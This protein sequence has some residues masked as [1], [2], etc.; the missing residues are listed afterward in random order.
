MARQDFHLFFDSNA[1]RFAGELKDDLEPARTALDEL[2]KYML[3]VDKEITKR[4]A[5]G[6]FTAMVKGLG[7]AN[8]LIGELV[9]QLGDMA[10]EFRDIATQLKPVL[11]AAQSGGLAVRSRPDPTVETGTS[12]VARTSESAVRGAD[13]DRLI[14]AYLDKRSE[15]RTAE[16]KSDGLS[17]NALAQAEAGIH[18]IADDLKR[19]EKNWK[20]LTGAE[21]SLASAAQSFLDNLPT[22]PKTPSPAAAVSGEGERAAEAIEKDVKEKAGSLAKRVAALVQKEAGGAEAL[23]A[24]IRETNDFQL[25]R[26]YAKEQ[27]GLGVMGKDSGGKNDTEGLRKK[28]LKAIGEGTDARQEPPPAAAKPSAPTAPTTDPAVKALK[29]NAE[30]GQEAVEEIVSSDAEAINA[31]I[32]NLKAERNALWGEREKIGRKV[33][34][35]P[36]KDKWISKHGLGAGPR[37]KEIRDEVIAKE[38]EISAE[39]A[40]LNQPDAG[41]AAPSIDLSDASKAVTAAVE[42][43]V[44]KVVEQSL[45][46]ASEASQT[47][48]KDAAEAGERAVSS[49]LEEAEAELARL[50]AQQG[51]LKT[52]RGEI[53]VKKG[54][55]F[56]PRKGLKDDERK[57]ATDE[58]KDISRQLSKESDLSQA[59]IAAKGKIEDF[60]GAASETSEASSQVAGASADAAEGVRDLAQAI[61]KLNDA[62]SGDPRIPIDHE[63]LDQ[64]K[65]EELT[66]DKETQEAASSRLDELKKQRD[67]ANDLRQSLGQKSPGRKVKDGR[68]HKR[69]GQWEFRDNST[70]DQFEAANEDY[71]RLDKLVKQEEAKATSDVEGADDPTAAGESP[72]IDA[73]E[74]DTEAIQEMAQAATDAS[75]RTREQFRA[76]LEE[77]MGQQQEALMEQGATREELRGAI[78]A[79]VAARFGEDGQA[80]EPVEGEE[81]RRKELAE[82]LERVRART[83]KGK[84]VMGQAELREAARG[85]GLG[86]E[87]GETN[88]DLAGRVERAIELESIRET[89]DATLQAAEAKEA[90]E[91]EAQEEQGRTVEELL[92]ANGRLREFLETGATRVSDRFEE[93]PRVK[94]EQSDRDALN[95]FKR[96]GGQL[97]ENSRATPADRAR[98][99]DTRDLAS[100]PESV[101][102]RARITELMDRLRF[103]EEERELIARGAG[104]ER[105]VID[106]ETGSSGLGEGPSTTPLRRQTDWSPEDIVEAIAKGRE[107]LGELKAQLD[108]IQP[109]PLGPRSIEL[110]DEA[111]LDASKLV[112]L[113]SFLQGQQANPE[114]TQEQRAQI[115]TQIQ[116]AQVQLREGIERFDRVDAGEFDLRVQRVQ[117]MLDA[118]AMMD[119]EINQLGIALETHSGD[120][121]K[122]RRALAGHLTSGQPDGVTSGQLAEMDFKGLGELLDEL[123]AERKAR[124]TDA[125]RVQ[126]GELLDR[127]V[128]EQDYAA[129]ALEERL[130]QVKEEFKRARKAQREFVDRLMNE[131][132]VETLMGQDEGVLAVPDFLQG[133][134]RDFDAGRPASSN[135]GEDLRQLAATGAAAGVGGIVI[136]GAGVQK[137]LDALRSALAV[138][139]ETGAPSNEIM[140][141]SGQI[142]S[143]ESR[144]ARISERYDETS[145]LADP[146]LGENARTLAQAI[147]SFTAQVERGAQVEGGEV[148]RGFGTNSPRVEEL[149]SAQ[150]SWGRIMGETGIQILPEGTSAVRD[151]PG[152]LT[153]SQ[154]DEFPNVLQRLAEVDAANAEATVERRKEAARAASALLAAQPDLTHKEIA[155]ILKKAKGSREAKRE[156]QRQV[157]E[158]DEQV[159]MDPDAVG[160]DGRRLFS[161]ARVAGAMA[162]DP[163]A[164]ARRQKRA[165]RSAQIRGTGETDLLTK[166]QKFDRN[167]RDIRAGASETYFGG[168]RGQGSQVSGEKSGVEAV[169]LRLFGADGLQ[170]RASTPEQFE[171]V[172]RVKDAVGEFVALGAKATAGPSVKELQD[173]FR[174]A[175]ERGESEEEL[176]PLK[177]RLEARQKLS[178]KEGESH[179]KILR[180]YDDLLGTFG[181][182][183]DPDAEARNREAAQL[184]E[185]RERSGLSPSE[186]PKVD[187]PRPDPDRVAERLGIGTERTDPALIEAKQAELDAAKAKEKEAATAAQTALD[188]VEAARREVERLD[189]AAKAATA[190]REV[191]EREAKAPDSAM[192][193]SA[194]KQRE[195]AEKRHEAN[196]T[197][198]LHKLTRDELRVRASELGITY[199]K[200][201]KPELQG[202]IALAEYEESG[203]PEAERAVDRATAEQRTRP[204]P[205][206]DDEILQAEARAGEEADAARRNLDELTKTLR[207]L[208]QVSETQPGEL[209][210]A[211]ARTRAREAELIDLKGEDHRKLPEEA[212]KLDRIQDMIELREAWHAPLKPVLRGALTHADEFNIPGE[213]DEE[214]DLAAL[215]RARL[216]HMRKQIYGDREKGTPP[217]ADIDLNDPRFNDPEVDPTEFIRRFREFEQEWLGRGVSAEEFSD[218]EHAKRLAE[219]AAKQPEVEEHLK[220][221]KAEAIKAEA[222]KKVPAEATGGG[223]KEC[224]DRIIEALSRIHQTLQGGLKITGKGAPD[225]LPPRKELETRAKELGVKGVSRKNKKD[226]AAEIA[227]NEAAT[228]SEKKLLESRQAAA[229]ST[230]QASGSERAR[231][232]ELG[233]IAEQADA[234]NPV[235]EGPSR[236]ERFD[237]LNQGAEGLVK[238]EAIQRAAELATLLQES[239]LHLDKARKLGGEQFDLVSEEDLERLDLRITKI[240]AAAKAERDMERSASARSQGAREGGEL[241]TWQLEIL[242]AMSEETRQAILDARALSEELRNLPADQ[243]RERMPELQDAQARAVELGRRDFE[244]RVGSGGRPVVDGTQA[245]VQLRGLMGASS[246]EF[247]DALAQAQGT[248][249]ARALS[250]SA[251]KEGPKFQGVL[252]EAFFGQSGFMSRSMRSMGTFMVRNLTSGMVFGI[253]R[254]FRQMMKE[255]LETEAQFIRVSDALEATGRSAEGVR[256]ELMSISQDL[257]VPLMEVFEIASNITGA[258]DDVADVEFGTRIVAQLEL[259]SGGALTAKNGFDAL[260][261]IASAFELEG[262]HELERIQDTA[263]AIQ[264]VM[265]I[266]I[267]DTI[268]GI[269]GMAGQAAEMNISL[270]ET[271]VLVAAVAKGT[272]QGGKAAAEQFGRILSTFETAKGRNVLLKAGVG[273]QGMFAE[274]DI[275]GVLVEMISGWDEL[276]EAQ[277]RNIKATFGSRREARAFNALINRRQ[278]IMSTLIET[279]NAHGL[280]QRRA[281]EIMRELASQIKIAGANFTNFGA[282]LVRSGALEFF[283]ILLRGFNN[284]FGGLNT[285]ISLLNDLADSN[286][287][288]SFA[289]ASVMALVGLQ[290][291][292]KGVDTMLNKVSASLATQA[293][294][295]G[296]TNVAALS[297]VP[298]LG[299]RIAAAAAGSATVATGAGAT[300]ARGRAARGGHGLLTHVAAGAIGRRAGR[301]AVAS[302]SS[303]ASRSAFQSEALLAGAMFGGARRG[304]PLTSAGRIGAPFMGSLGRGLQAAGGRAPQTFYTPGT[305]MQMTATTTR[306]TGLV[307]AGGRRVAAGAAGGAALASFG[308][309]MAKLGAT[310]AAG[311]P[312]AW[313][314]AAAIA[315]V[316]TGFVAMTSAAKTSQSSRDASVDA[317][318]PFLSEERIK[319]IEKERIERDTGAFKRFTQRGKDAR[320]EALELRQ[321]ELSEMEPGERLLAQAADRHEGEMQKLGRLG[322]AF[323]GRG[324]IGNPATRAAKLYEEYLDSLLD[325]MSIQISSGTAIDNPRQSLG[326]YFDELD[327]LFQEGPGGK[328]TADESKLPADPKDQATLIARSR[329]ALGESIAAQATIIEEGEASGELSDKEVIALTAALADLERAGRARIDRAELYM[330]GLRDIDLLMAD[331]VTA[332][333]DALSTVEGI[334]PAALQAVPEV[335]AALEG[336]FADFVPEGSMWEEVL[337]R[338]MSGEMDSIEMMETAQEAR[339]ELLRQATAHLDAMDP[340]DEEYDSQ[341]AALKQQ[342]AAVAQGQQQLWDNSLS[343]ARE[344]TDLALEIGRGSVTRANAAIS[345]ALADVNEQLASAPRGSIDRDRLLANARDLGRMKVEAGT[346]DLSIA[347]ELEAARTGDQLLGATAGRELAQRQLD[348][349]E[350]V[351]AAM[352]GMDGPERDAFLRQFQIARMEADHVVADAIEAVADA[353]LA[354]IQGRTQDPRVQ[355]TAQLMHAAQAQARYIA[356]GRSD[357]STLLRLQSSMDAAERSLIDAARADRDAMAQTRI[358]MQRDPEQRLLMEMQLARVQL[359]EAAA[360]GTAAVEAARQNLIQLEQALEDQRNQIRLGQFQMRIQ[361]TENPLV[362]ARLQVESANEQLRLASGALERQAAISAIVAARQ[363]AADAVNEVAEA[364]LELA[365]TIASASGNQVEVARIALESARRQL[366]QARERGQ[367]DAAIAA[368]RSAVIASEAGMR[369]AVLQDQLDTIEFNRTMGVMTQGQAIEALNEILATMDLTRDQRRGLLVQIKGLQDDLRNQLTGSGF[370]I[371]TEIDLPTAYQV[372]R[373]LGL[374]ELKSDRLP[375]EWADLAK[376]QIAIDSDLT[377][378]LSAMEDAVGTSNDR[379]VSLA[380]TGASEAIAAVLDEYKSLG[381]QMDDALGAL[382]KAQ[383]DAWAESQR[384]AVTGAKKTNDLSLSTIEELDAPMRAELEN[385]ASGQS[386]AWAAANSVALDGAGRVVSSITGTMSDGVAQVAGIVLGYTGA[387][388]DA[389]SPIL[390]FLG[391]PDIKISGGQAPRRGEGT[392][393]AKG[394]FSNEALPSN[395][396]IQSPQGRGLVQWAESS[397]HGEAFIP[398]SPANRPRSVEIW[399]ETG[400][401]LGV[402]MES[403]ATGGFTSQDIARAK[404]F[405]IAQN[406]KPYQWGGVGPS[407]YDCCLVAETLV[408]GPSGMKQIDELRPGDEVWSWV[409]GRM[410]AHKVVAQWRSID[411]ETFRVRTANRSIVASANHP[412]LRIRD[413]EAQ[414]ARVDELATEDMIVVL[415]E[416][417][418]VGGAHV[419]EDL[420]KALR[421]AGEGFAVQRVRGIEPMGVR[422]TYDIEVEGS[423]NFV[424]DGLVVHNSGIW[425]A[426]VNKLNNRTNAHQRLF[427]TSS[428]T[429]TPPAG[430]RPGLG[431]VSVG[432]VQGNPGHMSGTLAGLNV[433]SSGG[434]GVTLGANARGTMDSLYTSRFYLG[435]A[436]SVD[437]FGESLFEL[438]PVPEFPPGD[439]G[440]IGHAVAQDLR[441]RVEA[442]IVELVGDSFGVIG[443]DFLTLGIG[444][445]EGENGTYQSMAKRAL[446]ERG[447]AHHWPALN[448]LVRNESSWNPNA[449]N[450]SSSAYG[451]FQFLDCVPLDTRI[452]TQRGWLAHDE[453]RVGDSTLGFNPKT[454][455]NEWTPIQAVVIKDAQPL[456]RIAN[457]RWSARVTPGHRWWVER[458]QPVRVDRGLTCPECGATSGKRGPFVTERQVGNHRSRVHGWKREAVAYERAGQ[459]VRTDELKLNDRI[460][461]SAPARTQ[462]NEQ[463]TVDEAAII[464]WVLADGHIHRDA[465]TLSMSIYQSKPEQVDVLELLL[466]EVPHSHY[467]RQRGEHLPSHTFYLHAAYARDLLERS[468]VER[469]PE[470]FVLSLGKEQREAFLEAVWLAEGS[471][472]SSGP[473]EYL[474]VAQNDGPIQEAFVLAIYLSGFRPARRTL[475]RYEDHHVS[476]EM[477]GMA[478]P[479]V[480]TTAFEVEELGDEPVW[481]VQTE[482][483]TWTMMQDGQVS[484]TGNSTWAGTGIAK[485]SDPAMQIEAGLRYITNRYGTPSAALAHWQRRVPINGRDVGHWYRNGGIFDEESIIGV[486]E[487]GPEAV[488]PLDSRGVRFMAQLIDESVSRSGFAASGASG[489]TIDARSLADELGRVMAGFSAGGGDTNVTFDNV[490]NQAVQSPA[491]V[492]QVARAVVELLNQQMGMGSKIRSASP[493]LVG[494][495]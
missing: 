149:R 436:G 260:Q 63:A 37:L 357:P 194:L 438:P 43:A 165:E 324:Q 354:L 244:T 231:M 60:K 317:L 150:I 236:K 331:Q 153:K 111:A 86:I 264:N 372:R 347:A 412:F 75:G 8:T 287:L 303:V 65:R 129:H 132:P 298:V 475:A 22:V 126:A 485:T 323:F 128:H 388:A 478:R 473:N 71:K 169:M 73:I 158:L 237:E 156:I 239:G 9:E 434:K 46:E 76:A 203:L 207:R 483:G 215:K 382:S 470:A 400:R 444:T 196:K 107:Q 177:D 366:Q 210:Q 261:T 427:A 349:A 407:G 293:A 480:G 138:A 253:S 87:I 280:G 304:I 341:A 230:T 141:I 316:T 74:Q 245:N 243:R 122:A 254:M 466:K 315:A 80:A 205:P 469:D 13:E 479:W 204:R 145:E 419:D 446:T 24:K 425:S 30:V 251:I 224:C 393:F 416:A 222:I 219:D 460:R 142:S 67:A 208:N 249:V 447:M 28:L 213:N 371:P 334:S 27:G 386:T 147:E 216:A 47:L 118:L 240:Q 124:S 311:G 227:A 374:D 352:D 428:F 348:D 279:E 83:D 426:V 151:M 183:P 452:L 39:Y 335:G 70:K 109:S 397:T 263:V 404:Q 163:G 465:G 104:G 64:R 392:F 396:T 144:L 325:D 201:L 51:E 98:M 358:V 103:L 198:D 482:L 455:E 117:D 283:G 1:S 10:S 391:L 290:F 212:L 309:G 134:K 398:L 59:I 214:A 108:Q 359:A 424:A 413:G 429:G 137:Q 228:D 487:A 190:A 277:Q 292:L 182:E 307:G 402:P 57:E 448:Q 340:A 377:S 364:Q 367:G 381:P 170:T 209:Q 262:V 345:A 238:D 310:L 423:H 195:E 346:A 179:K 489:G 380:R 192:L 235:A 56:V 220:A 338:F 211:G 233:A 274:G 461:V 332:M 119:D 389:L 376:P 184:R 328:V 248:Q 6:G 457:D 102:L 406:G 110:R 430:F 297:Q 365:S 453:V 494:T 123:G 90:A 32:E 78:D 266:G 356:S 390:G 294:M 92:E 77:Q 139:E 113:I 218:R 26:E 217:V 464:G 321:E 155:G 257:G 333:L 339:V 449:Q 185:A 417:L 351:A 52:R 282:V 127:D 456:V 492:Q 322:R 49:S 148:A 115:S 99:T 3:A 131:F 62:T 387:I 471:A 415:D 433:E 226:L 410:E 486:G 271:A 431:P 490:F 161:E 288:A 94:P 308:G 84:P 164:Q 395:A 421:V 29:D 458:R 135:L 54:R 445:T 146:E 420:A 89:L 133:P 36:H 97:A 35:G 330:L 172:A 463:L 362:A 319:E 157:V 234:I 284:V 16:K 442:R 160:S 72:A 383:N 370:N 281:E 440:A 385:L 188:E 459:F 300:A 295:S 369:D 45:S 450:P 314:A 25:L 232:E 53:G 95:L 105:T 273:N 265:A 11:A 33:E 350:R 223:F 353:E 21:K 418:D 167:L 143:A 34:K 313:A 269:G 48:A 5:G 378:P 318:R 79:V 20:S 44:S 302:P 246:G 23:I 414:W 360:Q 403:F 276:S 12:R 285:F 106:T 493:R 202:A 437:E 363:A 181:S 272:N 178:R 467:V 176:Q 81:A 180:A 488:I 19:M 166:R 130:E 474:Q 171:A 336:M 439:A 175:K 451:L 462:R 252:A 112:E 96:G 38:A 312:V 259:I 15:L 495:I 206:V 361:T 91:E 101:E 375:E 114:N 42:G 68:F 409:E 93:L 66:A 41:E 477:V 55:K 256:T 174:L 443:N 270:E 344:M 250:E 241:L 481:C 405:A 58:L 40:K 116:E 221:I 399:K 373:S 296:M 278:Q 69:K 2:A 355:A 299:P 154:M 411:Q 491:Q 152:A 191:A 197:P 337:D 326:T 186:R 468:Q 100:D 432:V 199:G 120:P 31:R 472:W 229:E 225:T 173:D 301:G 168:R 384:S 268:E 14:K 7:E 275:G 159:V 85:Q 394:G 379:I 18:L 200:M 125:R 484:L 320:A 422:A 242:E 401:R 193:T 121:E 306:G 4:T 408:S 189:E 258:F 441:D 255:A 342:A 327:Q 289:R 17:G 136:E 61:S 82:L 162:R 368:A 187:F 291:A 454:G 435:K 476:G 50:M 140:D 286:P 88:L 305:G 247:T 329:A 343:V 267:N